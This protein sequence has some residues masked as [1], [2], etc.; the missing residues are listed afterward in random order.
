[1]DFDADGRIIVPGAAPVEK[2]VRKHSWSLYK[3]NSEEEDSD[4]ELS[5]LE[6]YEVKGEKLNPLKFTNGK[7]QEDVVREVLSA[8]DAGNKIIFIKGVCGSGKCLDGKTQVFCKPLGNTYFGYH[9]ISSL[10]GKE[11]D[12]ISLDENGDL[13]QSKFKN[14]RETGVKKI[15]KLKTFTGREIL[16]SENHPFLT[17]DKTG[18]IW[19]SLNELNERSYVCLPNKIN[20][21]SLKINLEDSKLKILGH[22]ISEG[23]LGDIAGSPKYYQDKTI[24]PLIRQDY[25]S[26]LKRVFP[27]GEVIDKHQTEVTIVFRDHDTRNGTT[28]KLRLLVREFG[29]EGTKSGDKFVPE[30]IFNLSLGKIAV[31]L[32][33]LF[34]G[35]GSIYLKKCRERKQIII[36]YDSISK[37]LTLDIS[38]LLN[39]FGIQ[40]TITS[41]KFRE[42]NEYSW[43]INISNQE[44]IRK[45]IEN[46]G[47][48]GEKQKLA[49]ELINRCKVHKFTN[50]D[51]VPRIIRE[52]LKNKGYD[53]NQLDRFLNY[54]EIEKLRENIGFKQIRKNKLAETPCVFKQGKID[55]LRSHLKKV[56]SYVKDNVL[57]F[58]CNEQIIWDKIKSKDFLKKDLTYDL[59]VS[60]K[61]N[62][63]ANGIIVHNSAMALNLAKHFKK[64]SIVVPIKSLQDQY[65][66]DYT[67]KN[68]ILKEDG[69]KLK[70][71]VIK[72]R[73][74][75]DCKFCSNTCKAD[76][77]Q[78]PCDVELREKNMKKI[79]EFI[80]QNPEVRK[81]DF[82]S[83][84]DVRRISVAAAC[85][86]WS[87]VMGAETGGKVL[88]K[89]RKRKYMSISGKEY[90]LFERA[91]GCGYY[92]Q[93][94]SYI[95]ADVLIF[96]A[97]KYM[98]ETAM[99]R[100]P[101]TDL[102]VIDE[103]DDFLDSFANEKKINLNRFNSA[104]SSL[105]PETPKDK[106]TIKEMSLLA[107]KII[108]NHTDG[109]E[110]L[111]SHKFKSLFEIILE[112]PYLAEGED[113]NYY[114]AVFEAVKS[115]EDLVDETYV[116]LETSKQDQQSLFGGGFGDTVYV[117][118]VSINVS[119]RFKDLIE[120]NNVLVLMSG[121][122]HSESV[123]KDIFGLERFKIVDAETMS[124]G[125]ITKYRTGFEKNCKFE[126][127][128]SGMFTRGD[129]L[130]A[131]SSSIANAKP[132]VLVHVSTFA[133][134]PSEIEKK[135]IGFSNLISREEFSRLQ[136]DNSAFNDFKAGKT[137]VLFTTKCSRG[138]DFPGEQCNSIIVTK[139]PYPNIQGLFWQIL[140]KEQ[141]TKFMEFYM[142][143]ARRDLV[144]K[145][146]R[147]VRYKG[148]HVF[149]LSPDS[150][151]L[152]GKVD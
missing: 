144:Q 31:F 120:K 10:V 62:F 80:S 89:A 115:F 36:E 111:N 146:A 57:S 101:K 54:E 93:Y 77:P 24:S 127:F 49:L 100:K 50:I 5:V 94:H 136:L 109:I 92:Q 63:I 43:R 76:D 86:Y 41:H 126:N 29:L 37:K 58:I 131:L 141:P 151:V 45:Y 133:D 123:L 96:N 1:M 138:V 68:F 118:L 113:S 129:Y 137:K 59:E 104:L 67:Q 64:T 8:V 99:G 135:E 66:R 150:R 53:Y 87:P 30:V 12:I 38:L 18:L 90:A 84:T 128:K 110:K 2:P 22:L 91:K 75:F 143:K 55:F 25:I 60:E 72:G 85:P 48:L 142:D 105:V 95:D 7:T 79:L 124:P 39:R 108:A 98:L 121:T 27:D 152:D 82:S 145:V 74:N 32:Q 65:E 17:I 40:H 119:R 33:A 23:K 116:A 56:N 134:L 70:I 13:V 112:N 117:N 26:S 107:N 130:K 103:C 46:I 19:S 14:V 9:E 28:N 16:A 52:Y 47:F 148:D 42:N 97:M 102:E 139:Y 140:K 125:K 34:S 149:L 20:L 3:K 122:L 61:H 132:P 81:E 114:N 147:G 69:K 78:L 11:G 15:F 88:S 4:K 6:S 106:N 44:Q 51:K 73:G 83:V 21:D 35:D 71:A